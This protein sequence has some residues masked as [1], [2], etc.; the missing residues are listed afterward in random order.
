MNKIRRIENFITE[1]LKSKM[2]FVAGPRQSGKTTLAER[3]IDDKH[4]AYFSWDIPNHRLA[5]MERKLP[6]EKNFWVFDEIHKYRRWRNWLKGV[7]DE[8][9]KTHSMLVTGSARLEILNRGGDS[10]QGRYFLYRLHPFTLSEYLG[11]KIENVEQWLDNFINIPIEYSKEDFSK[12]K[13]LLEY[14]GFPEPLFHGTSRF[15]SRWKMLYSNRLIREELNE[16]YRF[17]QLDLIE[18]LFHRLPETVGSSLSY[19]KFAKDLEVASETISSWISAFENLFACFRILPFG[20]PKIRTIRKEQ[21]LYLWDWSRIDDPGSLL[22]NLVASHLLR[23]VHWCEDIYGLKVDLRYFRDVNGHEVD[24]IITKKGNPWFAV[25]VKSSEQ[26]LDRGLSYFLERVKCPYAFQLHL[27]S[28]HEYRHPKI[29]GCI[30]RSLPVT[31]FLKNL[32]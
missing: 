10:L 32:P 21:K 5:L 18:L 26:P 16:V 27:K 12:I 28:E 30:V 24:F 23:F 29:N 31:M 11:I 15:A 3:I 19:K 20:V 9:H 25:E 14:G 8:Y 4:G 7:Y 6:V 22:E 2:V 13:E 1:D 17:Q